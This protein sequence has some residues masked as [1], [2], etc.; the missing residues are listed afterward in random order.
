MSAHHLLP[1]QIGLAASLNGQHRYEDA[2]QLLQDLPPGHPPSDVSRQNHLA[3]AELGLWMS[4]E[5]EARARATVAEAE[6]L[7]GPAHYATL[8]A[9]TLLGSAI[10]WQAG[11]TRP[12][13][14]CKQMPKRGSSTSAR[15]TP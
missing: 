7:H 12:R 15:T 14:Y 13:R 3:V 9:G 10:A 8:R 11:V 2:R 6:R 4:G 5:A 1:V